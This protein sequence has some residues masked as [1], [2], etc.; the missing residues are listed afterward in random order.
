M[1]PDGKHP[2][3]LM[4]LFDVIVRSLSIIFERSLQLGEVPDEWEICPWRYS[5]FRDLDGTVSRNPFLRMQFCDSMCLYRETR[6]GVCQFFKT[7]HIVCLIHHLGEEFHKQTEMNCL[8]V[9]YM[10]SSIKWRI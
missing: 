6:M 7:L 9:K 1:G 8:T 2:R 10:N 4:E 5:K 3:V